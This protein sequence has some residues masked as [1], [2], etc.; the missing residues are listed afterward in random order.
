[1][2]EI[3]T[4][5]SKGLAQ[6]KEALRILKKNPK[7]SGI[8]TFT[9][10]K[11]IPLFK[12]AGLKVA[13]H[14]PIRLIGHDLGD[15]NL[16][17]SLQKKE[18]AYFL[19]EVMAGDTRTIGFHIY[20][21]VLSLEKHALKGAPLVEVDYGKSDE[22][23]RESMIKNLLFLEHEI[24]KS[25]EE[26]DKKRIMFET[27]PYANFNKVKERKNDLTEKQLRLLARIG[28][29]ATPEFLESV[30]EDKRIKD[31]KNIGFLFDTAHI[32]IA[33]Y[34]LTKEGM[35]KEELDKCIGRVI[36][37]TKGRVF[38]MHICAP[39]KSG[40]VYHDFQKKLERGEEGSEAMLKIAKMVLKSNPQ[41]ET[42]TI[43]VD[44]FQDPVTH[45]TIL[46]E[47]VDMVSKELK[48]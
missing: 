8:E 25:L 41:L 20:H 12:K 9:P 13:I 11:D 30:I 45:A 21:E 37:A 33:L 24:N 46:S 34:N 39:K 22:T 23:I 43:E 18:N 19:E 3:Y 16:I 27:Y 15:D 44:T 48:L 17:S 5:W 7:I 47:Q 38:E 42:I 14:N 10:E 28:M 1:M 31:N 35:I 32:F 4:S 26:K 6:S 29:F 40:E 36:E 2:I